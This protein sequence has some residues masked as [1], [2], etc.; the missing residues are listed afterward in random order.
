M[1]NLTLADNGIGFYALQ[2]ETWYYVIF[3]AET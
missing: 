1:V 3:S 2:D